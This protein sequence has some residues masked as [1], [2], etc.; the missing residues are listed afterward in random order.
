M[1]IIDLE[2]LLAP[3]V[4][5]NPSGRDLSYEPVFDE[6]K[7]ARRSDIEN[8]PQGDW[9]IKIKMAD[10]ERAEHLA[11]D[12]LT[13]HSKDLQVAVW[14]V[15]ALGHRYGF[16]GVADGLSLLNG[17]LVKFWD[18]LY[19]E[20]T[21]DDLELRIGRLVWLNDNLSLTLRMLPMTAPDD[22]GKGYGWARWQESRAVDNLARHNEAQFEQAL[23]EG[24]VDS[25]RWEAAVHGTSPAFYQALLADSSAARN[26]AQILIAT[27]DKQ[28]G[29]EAPSLLKITEVLN[30]VVKLAAKLAQDKG[31]TPG[32]LVEPNAEHV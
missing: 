9:K 16:A 1:T 29:R 25:E 20:M 15:E 6:I 5:I 13:R 26:A 2:T 11:I 14:L 30:D 17:L 32:A 19:P 3:C 8:L 23:K 21:D 24:K 4:G 22:A 27:V 10:C 28:F 7:E 18:S 31:A 12:V